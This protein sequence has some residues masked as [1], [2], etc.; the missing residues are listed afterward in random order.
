MMSEKDLNYINCLR[1]KFIKLS[2]IHYSMV[3]YNNV[4]NKIDNLIV[5]YN[6][7][8]KFLRVLGK[9]ETRYKI[10]NRFLDRYNFNYF[11]SD[12]DPKLEKI[13]IGIDDYISEQKINKRNNY[14]KSLLDGR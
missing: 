7:E 8:T 2:N 4:E 3:V 6:T 10:M 5:L 13:K 9:K 1:D 11:E 14:L 12:G